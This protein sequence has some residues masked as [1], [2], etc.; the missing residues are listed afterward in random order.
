MPDFELERAV[1]GLV[2]GIDEAGRGPWAGPVVAACAAIPD[3]ALL[4]AGINDS[5]KLSRKRREALFDPLMA[6]ALVG[7]GQAT[8]GEIDSLNILAA[9]L[10]AMRRSLD[11]LHEKHHI[12]PDF[13]LVDGNRLPPDLPCPARAIVKGD[14]KSLSI[15]SAS[16]VAKVTRDRIM[17]ALDVLHPGYGW[18]KNA[19]YGT[20]EHQAGLARLGVTEHHRTT[21]RPI[22]VLMESS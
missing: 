9:T 1:G 4:P 21:Y 22:Q 3:P 7:I 5:K 17:T 16:I 18:A 13:V 8:P 11:D 2:A 15:A 6:V 19:G 20:A 10:L 12:Q 14:A